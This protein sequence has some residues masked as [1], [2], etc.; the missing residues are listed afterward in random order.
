[1]S[2]TLT[3]GATTKNSRDQADSKARVA[4]QSKLTSPAFKSDVS[5]TNR[6]KL[7]II[8]DLHCEFSEYSPTPASFTS[9]VIVLPGDIWKYEKGIAW[10][11][12][13]WP[14]QRIIYVPG[15]HE[16]YGRNRLEILSRMRIA[17]KECDVDLLDND[18]LIIGKTR[19][20]GATLWTNFNLFSQ[21][22]RR[23]CMREAI[24]NLND[25]RVIHEGTRHFTPMD[26]VVL[27]EASVK[28][29]KEKLDTPFNGETI[30]VTHHLPSV[31]SVAERYKDD[32]LSACYASNLDYLMDG[33]KVQLWIHG[34][35]HDN[36]DYEINGSRVLCNPR[37]YMFKSGEIENSDFNPNLVVE[38]TKN[39][40]EIV[41]PVE[42]VT[43]K[44]KPKLMSARMRDDVIWAID[45]LEVHMHGDV[46]YVDL[47][48]LRTGHKVNVKDIVLTNDKLLK[49]LP[50][51]LAILPIA[52]SDIEWLVSE[53]I[54]SA[55]KT[56]REPKR[57]VN[58]SLSNL[59][60]SVNSG[61][62]PNLGPGNWNTPEFREA[63]RTGNHN[64]NLP[65]EKKN[66]SK[67]P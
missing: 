38:V 61:Y 22:Q 21:E 14:D 56:T 10:A 1:M 15:N 66:R 39:H 32:K 65:P 7:H 29:L 13:T 25:F 28:W 2:I 58:S 53:I 50:E 23:D 33:D 27:H 63:I 59:D 64:F 43:V 35:T 42:I 55:P 34:H 49:N 67:K 51:H 12:A 19:F 62:N 18:E 48:A 3:S 20:L 8:S 46:F 40:C 52:H 60:M 6:M 17:A 30:V 41:A 26:S 11:R 24:C 16:F 57:R 36:F 37:G 9:D 47:N 4:Q 44:V 45:G 54:K 5:R 31:L